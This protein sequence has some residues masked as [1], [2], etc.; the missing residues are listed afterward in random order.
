MHCGKP[1]K[2]GSLYSLCESCVSDVKWANGRF[3]RYCGKILED[4]YPDDVCGECKNNERA[5]DSGITCFQYT[6]MERLLIKEFKYHGKSYMARNFAEML[7][8]KIH[9]LYDTVPFDMVIPVPMFAAK[10]KKRGYNQAALLAG[11]TAERLDI[12]FRGDVLLR[13]KNT[14]PMNRLGISDREKNLKDAFR[15]RYGTEQLV[16]GRHILLVDDIYTTGATAQQCSKILKQAGA[17]K[18]TVLS[19]ASGRNQRPLKDI[20][21]DL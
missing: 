12:S 8:D 9:A 6:D 1:L 14:A 21:F 7:Q 19:L 20:T 13:V 2:R 3:C 10:E 11:Y 17:S 15:L 4:W 16:C 5:F 18:V